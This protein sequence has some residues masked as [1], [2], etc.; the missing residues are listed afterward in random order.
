MGRVGTAMDNDKEDF[1]I[2]DM[3]G[4]KG[5]YVKYFYYYN[6]QMMRHEVTRLTHVRNPFNIGDIL[7]ITR[8]SD[9]KKG[10]KK[11]MWWDTSYNGKPVAQI[12]HGGR[13]V[14]VEVYA[15]PSAESA[16]SDWDI[17]DL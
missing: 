15:K 5:A 11:S 7:K 4:V 16:A 14:Y 8:G 2:F 10:D 12:Y 3:Q 1:K 17:G 9:I 13:I 6:G